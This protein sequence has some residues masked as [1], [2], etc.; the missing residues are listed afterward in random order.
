[1]NDLVLEK[2]GRPITS[3][4]KVAEIFEKEHKNVL[5]DIESILIDDDFSRL[6]FELSNYKSRG[7]LYPEYLMTK[8]G[9]TLLVF[10]YTGDKA[11][12]FK[13]SYIQAFNEMAAFIQSLQAAL[14][15]I[16]KQRTL[17]IK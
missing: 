3:S 16:V 10:G 4:R 13:K 5:R 17:K 6:N 11:M 2:R 8:D 1:M 9:F 12:K 15:S 7:K 14:P